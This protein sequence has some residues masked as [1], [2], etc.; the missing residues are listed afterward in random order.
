M[1]ET[2]GAKWS[3]DQIDVTLLVVRVQKGYVRSTMLESHE[4]GR[5]WKDIFLFS[6]CCIL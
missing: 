5:D 4:T 1:S 2:Q 6:G 3:R